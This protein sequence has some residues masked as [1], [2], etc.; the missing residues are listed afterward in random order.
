MFSTDNIDH[1]K[2]IRGSHMGE[3]GKLLA[4]LV[5]EKSPTILNDQREYGKN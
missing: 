1:L 3:P 5:S 2:T 4:A